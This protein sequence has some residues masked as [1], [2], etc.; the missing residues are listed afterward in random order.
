MNTFK[1]YKITNKINGKIYVGVT[2]KTIEKRFK[3]HCK[4]RKHRPDL[5]LYQ[6]MNKYGVENFEIALVTETYT[7][8]DMWILEIENI[9]FHQSFYGTNLG[10]NMTFG[11]ENYQ[12]PFTSERRE[13]ISKTLKLFYENNPEAIIRLKNRI[14]TPEMRKQN[15]VNAKNMTPESRER[16]RQTQL[17]NKKRYPERK[18]TFVVISP[19]GE[20]ITHSGIKEFCKIHKLDYTCFNNVLKG[21]Q[22]YHNGW[23]IPSS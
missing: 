6:A 1:V 17:R 12:M 21:K 3:E 20:T 10:Y 8:E 15:S 23:T 7:E 2:S 22:K 11:G 9:F 4:H 5:C 16:G 18:R 13:K 14:I 19:T